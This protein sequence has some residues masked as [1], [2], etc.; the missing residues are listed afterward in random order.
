LPE[1]VAAGR[2]QVRPALAEL[3]AHSA[4]FVD[5][6]AAP[7]DAVILATGYRPALGPVEHLVRLSPT[8]RPLVDLACRADGV[9]GLYCVGYDYP[10]TAG[11]LQRIGA[12][13]RRAAAAIVTDL[14]AH[15][16]AIAHD[17]SLTTD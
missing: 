10:T 1:A 13:A 5:G 8:G 4:H 14:S 17:L 15:T 16:P 2:V 11:W 12:V 3:T 9:P 6:S 7:Y